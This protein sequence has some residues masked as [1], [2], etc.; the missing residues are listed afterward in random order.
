[1]ERHA[2]TGMTCGGRPP[3]HVELRA[4]LAEVGIHV[5]TATLDR[6]ADERA[7]LATVLADD[8]RE[9]VRRL[10]REQDRA[11]FI[12]RRAVLR[13]ILG[14]YIGCSPQ[15][16]CFTA[17]RFGRPALRGPAAGLDV[18]FSATHSHALAVYAV[19]HARHVGVD[20]ERV[21][22][23]PELER[24][25]RHHFAPGES[26]ALCALPPDVRTTAFLHCWTRKEA[27]VKALGVGLSFPLDQFEVS[28]RPDAP[29]ALL[30]DRIHPAHAGA[31]AMHDLPLGDEYVGSVTAD[32]R[33]WGMRLMSWPPARG[34]ACPDALHAM[35]VPS[36]GADA[37]FTCLTPP[38]VHGTI[39]R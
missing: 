28:V 22:P 25:A 7:R 16:V 32:G 35:S 18:R 13:A 5:W 27:Y 23:I 6:S 38:D 29:A 9:R 19:A 37:A 30:A 8:E 24:I 12:V 31:W 3:P 20:V 26:A 1:M 4:L 14:R 34:N 21:R 10:R 15:D 11:R 2:S 36:D 17:N 33:D 39:A